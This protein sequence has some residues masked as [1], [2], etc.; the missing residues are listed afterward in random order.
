MRK[1]ILCGAI[2]VVALA[3]IVLLSN[4]DGINVSGST[5]H[6]VKEMVKDGDV[7]KVDYWLTVDGKLI[8]T[9]EGRGLFSFT[10][11]AGQ[12]I[13]GFDKAVRGMAV[14]ETKD[15]DLTGADAY[16]SGELAGKTLHF[17]IILRAIN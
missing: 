1:K 15:V 4:M 14:G 5:T 6:E 10:V 2:I 12:V 8:D 16:T 13:P 3:V 7:V 9:S 17:K 11:G